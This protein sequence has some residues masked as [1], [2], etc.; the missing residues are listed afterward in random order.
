MAEISFIFFGLFKDPILY[1]LR[2]TRQK[3][4]PNS[5]LG[6]QIEVEQSIIKKY[7][8]FK[9]ELSFKK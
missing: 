1:R 2:N 7:I 4:S 9:L 6:V 5:L 8:F 3:G